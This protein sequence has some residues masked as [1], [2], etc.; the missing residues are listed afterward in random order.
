MLITNIK[1]TDLYGLHNYDITFDKEECLKIIHA[2]NGYGK[3]TILK[4]IRAILE[5]YI[6][7]LQQIPFRRFMIVCDHAISVEVYKENDELFYHFTNGQFEESYQVNTDKNADLSASILSRLK[8][9]TKEMPIYLINADRLWLEKKEYT[10]ATHM[11]LPTVLEYAKELSELMREALAQSNYCGQELDRSFPNRLINYLNDEEAAYLSIEEIKEQ[12]QA[13][14][15]KRTILESAGLFSNVPVTLPEELSQVDEKILKVLTLYIEDSH[16]KLRAFE[17]LATK[18]NLLATLINKRF[19]YKV[20]EVNM[21]N[22]FVFEVPTKEK[23]KAD[24][25]SSGEQNE[26]ILLFKLLFKSPA[27]ALILIDEPEISLH[28]AWQQSFLEDMEAIAALTQVKLIIA[29]HSP[30][31]I[32]GRWDLT[33]GLEEC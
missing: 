7:E 30:D 17:S 3:T 4:L 5:G 15:K 19:S 29:T 28:I 25:L 24:K 21:K 27:N 23:L 9:I 13:L 20:M 22:G 33:T 1:V 2:P 16:E 31:I 8:S 6:D 10:D 11:F 18:I 14:E 32:N 26:L 12:L